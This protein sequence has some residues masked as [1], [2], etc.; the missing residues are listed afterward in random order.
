MRR[1]FACCFLLLASHFG[2]RL[3]AQSYAFQHFGTRSGL[4]SATVYM[5]Q[6]DDRGFIWAGT[7]RGLVRYDG[8]EFRTFTV[9]DG[10]VN[11][12]VWGLNKD[13]RG[14]IWIFSYAD[15]I[16]YVYRDSIHTLPYRFPYPPKR[17]VCAAD[18]TLY[19]D[20]ETENGGQIRLK[21]GASLHEFEAPE[22]LEG[23][24]IYVG[25]D[26]DSTDIW[27]SVQGEMWVEFAARGTGKRKRVSVPLDGI[28][29]RKRWIPRIFPNSRRVIFVARPKFKVLDYHAGEVMQMKEAELAEMKGRSTLFLHRSRERI[30]VRRN[31]KWEA[32]DVRLRLDTRFDFLKEA[33]FHFLMEDQR[34]NCWMSAP[35]GG[36]YFA[37]RNT[38]HIRNFGVEEGLSAP[39][40]RALVRVQEGDQG[41][42]YLAHG[43]GKVDVYAG[44]KLQKPID[45]G[46]KDSWLGKLRIRQ[47]VPGKNGKVLGVSGTG[48]FVFSENGKISGR[49]LGTAK[50]TSML[51]APKVI[52]EGPEETYWMGASH[53]LFR[54]EEG[55]MRQIDAKAATCMALDEEGT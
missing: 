18:G 31:G 24:P 19:F 28:D 41:K 39:G 26:V 34:G 33:D 37:S 21:E 10:L 11:N 7:D 5:I 15:E 50:E 12:D 4:P 13:L 52:A 14:R 44:R 23:Q 22:L 53:G 55:K 46:K 2:P 3:M 1:L 25:F 38:P 35:D 6:Q 8:N 27:A 17:L 48:F 43:R 29:A 36:L 32:R 16:Q 54:L 40:V 47:L 45:V 49:P 30:F 51:V 9:P 42:L 20:Y